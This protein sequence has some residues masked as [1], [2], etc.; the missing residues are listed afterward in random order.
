MAGE[1]E[2][3]A[4][5]RQPA[6]RESGI[7]SKWRNEN[8]NR[9]NLAKMAQHGVAARGGSEKAAWIRSNGEMPKNAKYGIEIESWRSWRNSA[10]WLA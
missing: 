1:E 3:M 7:E 10:I 8:L 9:R 2:D 6:R 5:K 4:E